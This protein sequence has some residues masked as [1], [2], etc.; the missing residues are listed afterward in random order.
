MT[1]QEAIEKIKPG[2][3]VVVQERIKEKDKERTTP[4]RGIVLARKHGKQK[5]ATF[6][7]RSVVDGVGVEKV[8]PFHSPLIA[9]VNIVTEPTR[10]RRAKLYYLKKV[11]KRMSRKKIGVSL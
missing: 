9:S 10:V 2:M 11:S 1:G 6:T 5:N 4:F 3:L 8:Y 7:V